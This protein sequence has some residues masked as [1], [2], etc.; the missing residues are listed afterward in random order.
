M[1]VDSDS[2]QRLQ[3]FGENDWDPLTGPH[4][5]LFVFND[6]AVWERC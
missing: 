3:G 2:F 5:F 4:D 1:L 6:S